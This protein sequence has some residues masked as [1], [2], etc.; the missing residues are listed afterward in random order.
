[1]TIATKLTHYLSSHGV[2]FEELPHATT[3]TSL[4][5]AQECHVPANRLAKAVLLED[6][7]GYL[8][9]VLP[10]SHHL[11]FPA[12]E[13]QRQ[14]PV[15]L[16]QED[17]IEQVFP[18]CSPG[19]VPPIGAAYGID[20]IVDDSI[21][22]QSDIFFEGGDHKTLLHVSGP[23]FRALMADAQHGNFSTH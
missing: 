14:N 2:P 12:L 7:Y 22:M 17:E 16:A 1:M 4:R 23:V 13:R 18:D 9:A 19:A 8:L 20:T 11:R 10:A 21:A 15:H 3:L 5:T 6:D